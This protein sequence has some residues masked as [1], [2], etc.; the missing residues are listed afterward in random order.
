M[1]RASSVVVKRTSP[2]SGQGRPSRQTRLDPPARCWM[3]EGQGAEPRIGSNGA[4]PRLKDRCLPPA[5]RAQSS[6]HDHSFAQAATSSEVRVQ[7]VGNRPGP[8]PLRSR[9]WL[10][11]SSQR[12]IAGGGRLRKVGRHPPD[13]GS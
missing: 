12:D 1:N 9:H 11:R 5:R 3:G 6:P 8:A 4:E 13:E 2:W 10:A 7:V